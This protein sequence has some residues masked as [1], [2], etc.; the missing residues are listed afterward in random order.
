MRHGRFIKTAL[1]AVAAMA[2]GPAGAMATPARSRTTPRRLY[3]RVARAATSTVAPGSVGLQ[4]TMKTEPFNGP[5]L[6][7]G[8]TPQRPGPPA[9]TGNRRTVTSGVLTVDGARVNGATKY[10][11]P[12]PDPGV[13]RDVS[14]RGDGFQHVGF[15]NTLDD[16]PWAMFS[17]GQ[18]AT[19]SSART[20]AR[21]GTTEAPTITP[22][23]GARSD[24]AAHLPHRVVR[25]GREVLR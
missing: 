4:L 17:T 18:A 8:T 9:S 23:T 13:P 1:V 21:S 22:I 15:G 24:R 7:A 20:L 5:G 10:R 25:N 11:G 2:I 16:G 19:A 14:R 12:G 3:R 6:P